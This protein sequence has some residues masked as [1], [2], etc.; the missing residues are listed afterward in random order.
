[1]PIHEDLESHF[2]FDRKGD[3][4]IFSM[5]DGEA[6]REV[7]GSIPWFIKELSLAHGLHICK[8]RLSHTHKR[9]VRFLLTDLSE[10][11][12]AAALKQ[13]PKTTH[14]YV[15]EIYRKY[16]V[17]GRAGLMSLWLNR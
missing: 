4:P 17:R 7:I 11:E 5:A 13:S 14:K 6:I 8:E 12:I 3:R 16:G 2:I 9:I 1:V 15:T 10:P